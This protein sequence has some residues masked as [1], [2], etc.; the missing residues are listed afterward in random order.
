MKNK[1]NKIVCFSV[2]ILSAAVS[3][4]LQAGDSAIPLDSGVRMASD[5]LIYNGRV[6]TSRDADVLRQNS[7]IDLSTLSPKSND[8]WDE[9]VTAVDDQNAI[10]INN[11]DVTLKFWI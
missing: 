2:L 10:A 3:S 6:L 11:D 5:D 1:L 8:I 4:S 7:K 9:A